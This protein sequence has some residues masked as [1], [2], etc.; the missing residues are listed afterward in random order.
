MFKGL[1]DTNLP[2]LNFSE[3]STKNIRGLFHIS[4][5]EDA[6]EIKCEI[7]NTTSFLNS[8]GEWVPIPDIGD[9]LIIRAYDGHGGA[10]K[11]YLGLMVRK[12]QPA[13]FTDV[14]A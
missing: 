13:A 14:L 11:R 8:R 12:W 9:V 10:I 6:N 5:G 4:Q 2:T 1:M 3:S 7:E